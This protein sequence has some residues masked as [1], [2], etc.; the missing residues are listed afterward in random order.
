MRDEIRIQL[1]YPVVE[2]DA[3]EGWLEEKAAK[4]LL[5]ERI[6]VGCFGFVAFRR[7]NPRQ[8]RYRID[9]TRHAT[10]WKGTGRRIRLAQEGW[11]FV[12]KFGGGRALYQTRD[13][14]K[15]ELPPGPENRLGFLLWGDSGML[16]LLVLA[17]LNLAIFLRDWPYAYDQWL[18]SGL[19]WAIT[20]GG[21]FLF[22]LMGL[23]VKLYFMRSIRARE[24]A[25]KFPDRAHHTPTRA[26]ARRVLLWVQQGILLVSVLGLVFAW[27][28]PQE[29]RWHAIAGDKEVQSI[30]QLRN[31]SAQ[32]G[33][34]LTLQITGQLSTAGGGR[35]EVSKSKSLLLPKKLSIVQEVGAV[36]GEAASSYCLDDYRTAWPFL[37][38]I[39][40]ADYLEKRA[41]LQPARLS[42][43]DEVEVYYGGTVGL[44]QILILHKDNRVLHVRYTGAE[45]LKT[46]VSLFE[47]YLSQ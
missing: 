9:D 43:S 37:A 45:N 33:E 42:A 38:D 34:D 12:T 26:S 2:T 32:E 23:L 31:V 46:C 29:E 39:L 17:V 19:G 18:Q 35:S 36:E 13:L 22:F 3:I 1:P 20:L 5:V 4:G 7:E 41:H 16:F 8:V 27:H 10:N 15:E 11:Q 24:R 40:L 47:R 25:G 21:L 6:G 14:Q 28:V 30:P 44:E